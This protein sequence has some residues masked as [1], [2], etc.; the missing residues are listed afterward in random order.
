MCSRSIYVHICSSGLL[1]DTPFDVCLVLRRFVF[2]GAG[3]QATERLRRVK[4]ELRELTRGLTA[5]NAGGPRWG[6]LQEDPEGFIEV[7]EI[8][9]TK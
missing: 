4:A 3:T 6:A 5:M 7:A 8:V 1:A 9:C 2:R